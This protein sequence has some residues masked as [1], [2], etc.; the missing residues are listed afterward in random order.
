MKPPAK[1]KFLSDRQSLLGA[2]AQA[3]ETEVSDTQTTEYKAAKIR[4]ICSIILTLI[5]APIFW[6]VY[7]F[8]L[9][10]LLLSNPGNFWPSGFGSILVKIAAILVTTHSVAIWL[11]PRNQ[12]TTEK[13][14]M[15]LINGISIALT[16]MALIL[17][18][19]RR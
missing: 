19:Q 8:W 12:N 18:I 1:G 2:T 3:S 11:V 4:S 10:G 9:M 5:V 17:A 15:I 6:L 16:V 14:L 7:L 13:T